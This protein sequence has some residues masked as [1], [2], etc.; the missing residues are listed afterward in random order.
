MFF[1]ECCNGSAALLL[2]LTPNCRASYNSQFGGF[3]WVERD[4]FIITWNRIGDKPLYIIIIIMIIYIYNY[5]YNLIYIIICIYIYN[6]IYDYIYNYDYN[7][8]I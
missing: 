4:F 3:A 5:I 8:Y 1:F 2:N 6:Y 7:D